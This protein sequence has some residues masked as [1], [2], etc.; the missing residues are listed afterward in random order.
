MKLLLVG[1]LALVGSI[2]SFAHD[3][4]FGPESCSVSYNK[5]YIPNRY[6][7]PSYGDLFLGANFHN[8]P[9]YYGSIS[10]E[11]C[12]EIANSVKSSTLPAGKNLKLKWRYRSEA[13]RASGK[14]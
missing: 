13:I 10:L 11:R 6:S 12:V 2:S 4:K 5:G 3:Q 14:F 9:T 7:M 8:K 1:L